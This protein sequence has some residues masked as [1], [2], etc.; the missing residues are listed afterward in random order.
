MVAPRLPKLVRGLLIKQGGLFSSNLRSTLLLRSNSSTF[1][2][3]RV[4]R[5][6]ISQVLTAGD[7]RCRVAPAPAL[8]PSGLALARVHL[9]P[10]APG[11]PRPLVSDAAFVTEN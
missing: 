5:G 10:W 4:C 6:L 9:L 11:L 3:A 1:T 7:A 8:I 2:I